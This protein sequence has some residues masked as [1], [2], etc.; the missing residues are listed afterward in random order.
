MS[1]IPSLMGPFLYVI[2]EAETRRSRYAETRQR[3]WCRG[4]LSDRMW[5]DQTLHDP[6]SKTIASA[7]AATTTAQST[8]AIRCFGSATIPIRRKPWRTNGSAARGAM[9]LMMAMKPALKHALA[10]IVLGLSLAAPV[11]ADLL[12]DANAAYSR[13]DYATAQWLLRALANQGD[14]G[15]QTNLGFMYS[16]GQGVPK[17]YVRAHLWLTLSAAQGDQAAARYRDY[18]AKLM[19]PAQ[20]AESQKLARE[21]RPAP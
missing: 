14:A 13:R 11:A 19:T 10:A 21:W 3:A 16:K 17:D 7:A 12:E 9:R 18:V 5:N 8:I 4:E 1:H 6:K 15:A 2:G 20:I